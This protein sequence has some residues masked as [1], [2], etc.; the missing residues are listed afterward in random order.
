MT[1]ARKSL[2]SQTGR[3]CG[4]FD[5]HA[6]EKVQSRAQNDDCRKL[7]DLVPAGSD[8]GAENVR[9]Q[10]E[11]ER[12]REPAAQF[13]PDILL[14]FHRRRVVGPGSRPVEQHQE[15]APNSPRRGRRDDQRRRGL[16]GVSKSESQLLEERFHETFIQRA[17]DPVSELE[18]LTV[19]T[20]VTVLLLF[21]PGFVLHTAP[22]FPGS[23]IGSLLGIAAAG[24]MVLLL[25]YPA[26]KSYPKLRQL[27][28]MRALLSFHVYAGAL[29]A[30]LGIL[31]TGHKFESPLGIVLV[32]AMLVAVMSGF[33]GRYYLVHLSGELRE[34]K[35]TLDLLR[36]EYD[37]IGIGIT[38]PSR[39]PALS[40]ALRTNARSLVGAIGDLEHAIRRREGI[41]RAFAIW[42]GV[43]IAAALVMYAALALHVWNGVYFGLRWL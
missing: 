41:K 33:V 30:I 7:A 18:K 11:F 12:Q 43:H 2:R 24:L 16:D 8:R 22:R 28:S 23:L 34:Q 32:A 25:A 29:G 38:E 4:F 15:S 9:R 26:I 31:H 35:A 40:F 36:A 3:S 42:M 20:L 21:T 1:V 37:R 6:Q 27:I 19:G 5:F 14:A 10:L 17:G 13:E 39:L